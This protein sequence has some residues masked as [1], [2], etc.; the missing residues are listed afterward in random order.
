MLTPSIPGSYPRSPDPPRPDLL[1]RA[2][3]KWR[4]G[5][6][7]EKELERAFQR[8]MVEALLEVIA[9]GIE[10]ASDGHIRWDDPANFILR[11]LSGI[12]P[13]PDKLTYR[14]VSELSQKINKVSSESLLQRPRVVDCIKWKSPILVDD[15][16]FLQERAPIDIRPTL[17]GPFSLAHSVEPGYYLNRLTDLIM[18]I[19]YALN[20]EL[21]GL[22]EA[23]SKY[24]LIEEPLLSDDQPNVEDFF[25]A[26]PIL[27]ANIRATIFLSGN[28]SLAKLSSQLEKLPFTGFAFDL[29]HNPANQEMLTTEQRF[30]GR[31]IE[32][33]LISS[34][35]RRI[36]SPIEVGMGILKYAKYYDPALLWVAPTGPFGSL[37]RDCAFEK[38]CNMCKGIEWARRNLA[39][40]EVPS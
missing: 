23:G 38:L 34:K 40:Q 32:L 1:E 35:D 31:I 4:A 28:G 9:A 24:I 33:G 37:P 20:R 27:C 25:N 3:E 22:V 12:E 17:T 19:A 26:A 36:E 16:R 30:E 6:L 2:L 10:V 15:F 11:R 18:D 14:P 7:T 29:I 13:L 39:K 8:A 5:N 21:E